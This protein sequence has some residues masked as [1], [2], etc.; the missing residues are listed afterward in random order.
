MRT[1]PEIAIEM[2]KFILDLSGSENSAMEAA[3]DMLDTQMEV[4]EFHKLLIEY[5]LVLR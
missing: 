5:L 3:I 1:N 4:D 2:Y